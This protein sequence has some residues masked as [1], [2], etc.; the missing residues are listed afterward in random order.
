[1]LIILLNKKIKLDKIVQ[2]IMSK[3]KF[4]NK[5]TTHIYI[6]KNNTHIYFINK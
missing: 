4:T 3:Y 6:T 2:Y 5:T 1:M